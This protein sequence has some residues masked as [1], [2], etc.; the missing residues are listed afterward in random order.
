MDNKAPADPFPTQHGCGLTKAGTSKARSLAFSPRKAKSNP[1]HFFYNFQSR[2][3]LGP[4]HVS[5]I[6]Q[7]YFHPLPRHRF[8]ANGLFLWM[9]LSSVSE[10]ERPIRQIQWDKFREFVSSCHSQGRLCSGARTR[11]RLVKMGNSLLERVS[12]NGEKT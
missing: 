9:T 6:Y 5:R 1:A 8:V 4:P 11:S 10:E 7:I 12:L 3:L 2:D